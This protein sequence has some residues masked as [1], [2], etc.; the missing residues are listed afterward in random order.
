MMTEYVVTHVLRLHRDI[1]EYQAPRTN[2]EWSR[3][4]IVRPELG[5]KAAVRLHQ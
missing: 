3:T 1:P 2:R 5:P 4:T